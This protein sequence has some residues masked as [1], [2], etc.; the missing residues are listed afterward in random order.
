MDG[1]LKKEDAEKPAIFHLGIVSELGGQTNSRPSISTANTSISGIHLKERSESG[2]PTLCL[3]PLTSGALGRRGMPPLRGR[4][5][6]SSS[7]VTAAAGK[8]AP[9]QSSVAVGIITVRGDGS[10]L[11]G[12]GGEPERPGGGMRRLGGGP[13]FLEGQG[14]AV[15]SQGV[16]LQLADG[17]RGEGTRQAFVRVLLT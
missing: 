14:L 8:T 6:S 4:I 15:I 7:K 1:V 17:H 9:K 5:C 13:Q 16:L 2:A 11:G 12:G 3:S 10:L